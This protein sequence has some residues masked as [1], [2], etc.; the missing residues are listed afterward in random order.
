MVYF[1]SKKDL[2]FMYT[3]GNFK[4]HTWKKRRKNM[5]DLICNHDLTK[6]LFGATLF[7]IKYIIRSLLVRL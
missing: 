5:L 2:A 7:F 1:L 6:K 3:G 4:L